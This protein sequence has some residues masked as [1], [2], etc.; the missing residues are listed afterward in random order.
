MPSVVRQRSRA[1]PSMWVPPAE[2][3]TVLF[4]TSWERGGTGTSTYAVTDGGYF[5]ERHGDPR[6]Y[7]G[8]PPVTILEVIDSGE[9]IPGGHN[10]LRV[11]QWGDYGSDMV[12]KKPAWNPEY[13]G[14][15][16]VPWDFALRY[17]F[18][19]KDTSTSW[20]H[21]IQANPFEYDLTWALMKST[22]GSA[23]KPWTMPAISYNYPDGKGRWSPP[24]NPLSLNVWYRIEF[25]F[26]FNSQTQFRWWPRFYN[27]SGTLLYDPY[28]FLDENGNTPYLGDWYDLGNW[29]TYSDNWFDSFFGYGYGAMNVLDLGNNGQA[30]ATKTNLSWYFSSMKVVRADDIDPSDTTWV[31]PI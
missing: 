18:K 3:Q 2:E 15:Y 25:L 1:V 6:E 12:A 27:T 31:G 20:D 24:G 21:H 4:E 30:G 10:A 9:S 7:P 29:H 23:W 13:D 5:N 19:T 8:G 11:E 22:N 14:R 28:D 16:D 17:Y 26:K